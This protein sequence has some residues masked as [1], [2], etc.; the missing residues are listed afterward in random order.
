M[1]K[2]KLMR[3][4]KRCDRLIAWN[5]SSKHRIH[6]LKLLPL[7]SLIA[8]VA[9]ARSGRNFFQLVG[10]S[11]CSEPAWNGIFLQIANELV[12]THVC[13][14]VLLALLIVLILLDII[15]G[16]W[17]IKRKRNKSKS[18]RVTPVSLSVK[19]PIESVITPTSVERGLVSRLDISP[20]SA[21]TR[22]TLSF[23][24]AVSP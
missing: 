22:S 5:K 20:T 10:E 9:I 19:I 18:N 21:G 13:D 17:M 12:Q 16:V 14:S 3:C 2:N 23:G 15:I 8:A 7:P 6:L 24:N 11:E 4:Q 1:L